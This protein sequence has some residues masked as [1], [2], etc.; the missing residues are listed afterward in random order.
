MTPGR[1]QEIRRVENF[2]FSLRFG[3]LFQAVGIV[4]SVSS[5][6]NLQGVAEQ[7][8]ACV[9]SDAA[10]TGVLFCPHLHSIRQEKKNIIYLLSTLQ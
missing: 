6:I 9:R 7:L 10:L 4:N 1:P 8:Q 3:F 2:L 5:S